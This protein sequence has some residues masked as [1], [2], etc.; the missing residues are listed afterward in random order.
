MSLAQRKPAPGY[1]YLIQRTARRGRK[2]TRGRCMVCKQEGNGFAWSLELRHRGAVPFLLRMAYVG[3]RSARIP[4]HRWAVGSKGP[5]TMWTVKRKM[6]T[7]VRASQDEARARIWCLL[8]QSV[9]VSTLWIV[10]VG[11]RGGKV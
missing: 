11:I 10:V 2:V 5:G 8:A 7:L 3:R 4:R 9:R 1:G 6:L